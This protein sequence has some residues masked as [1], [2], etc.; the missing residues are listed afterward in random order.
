[1]GINIPPAFPTLDMTK[2]YKVTVDTYQNIT[3]D[4]DCSDFYTTTPSACLNGAQ[5]QN[6]IDMGWECDWMHE[7]VIVPGFTAQRLVGLEG[8]F[9]TFIACAFP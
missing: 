3:G 1:M 9:D 8:P 5:I 7:L 4:P 2:F 6:W